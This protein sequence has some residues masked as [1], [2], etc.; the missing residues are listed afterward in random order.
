MR[1]QLVDWL[2]KPLCFDKRFYFLDNHEAA[3][4]LVRLLNWD[5]VLELF[6]YG[7]GG[8]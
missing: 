5:K 8:E 6:L 4:W 3:V 1:A 7:S 2:R